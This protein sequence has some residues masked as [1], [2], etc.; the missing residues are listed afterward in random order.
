M[1]DPQRVQEI[2]Q[3]MVK[4]GSNTVQ[5]TNQ[6][7]RVIYPCHASTHDTHCFILNCKGDIYFFLV[8]VISDFDMTLTR[9]AYNGKRCPTCHSK[10]A[11]VSAEM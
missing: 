10:F 2:L 6:A 8:K 4:A 5:V 11:D 7:T 3:S 1:K 9:F